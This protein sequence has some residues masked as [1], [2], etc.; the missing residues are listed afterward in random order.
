LFFGVPR[1][2]EKFHAAISGKLDAATGAK[3]RLVDWARRVGAKVSELRTRGEE[4]RGLLAIEY[5]LADK[6]VFSK[7]KP[8]IGLGRAR[9][10]VSGAA[11]IAR[12]VL[13]FFASLDIL[14][15]EV[16]GQS[17]DCGPTSFNRPGRVKFGTVG[18]AVDGVEVKIADDGEILVRGPNVFLGYY[19]D[20]EATAET[21]K[22]G[23]LCS[24][25]LGAF[26]ADGFLTIT[27]RKK[28]III[29]AGGKNI[30]PKNIE[31]ALKNHRL[32][33][34]AVVIG[35]RRKFLTVLLTLDPEAA[36]AFAKERGIARPDLH[37]A[38]EVAAEIQRAVDEVNQ[39]LA[40]VETVKKFTILP[41]PFTIDAGELTPTLKVKRKVV[42]ERYAKEID[43]MYAD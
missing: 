37:A 28:E 40:R 32:V 36:Q 3:K 13:E 16:Y 7:L 10:C 4:P 35:D 17:E 22:D 20:P 6:L 38:P 34:E 21:L 23:W 27:G 5:R 8:A 29:T 39:D 19:K 2:W 11:P 1:I 26:D 18:P 24:G 41:Q 9:F 33:S 14:V 12:E 30:A 31:A 25:D 15:F 43:A 42:G